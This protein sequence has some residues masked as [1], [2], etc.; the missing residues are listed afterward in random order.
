[1]SSVEKPSKKKVP[2]WLVIAVI[3]VAVLSFSQVFRSPNKDARYLT[4]LADAT[5]RAKEPFQ[6]FEDN[7]PLMPFDKEQ[8]IKSA[9]DGE[10]MLKL[11]PD[12]T[13]AAMIAGNSYMLLDQW[14]KAEDRLKIG[15]AVQPKNPTD[16]DKK[17]I[18][19]NHYLLAR[20]LTNRNKPEE[21]EQ[22]ATEAIKLDEI[23]DYHWA[24]AQ[25]RVQLHKLQEAEEDCTQALT[26]APG[27]PA[28]M[29]LLKYIGNLK[30]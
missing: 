9:A 8:V 10:E 2:I 20:T 7:E 29:A 21:A 4:L 15:L 17:I 5:D 16:A 18:A 11:R 13:Q 25:A 28:S 19:R 30:G 6:K 3:A 26:L 24:R 27:H 12:S 14:D 22:E 23:A 1:L